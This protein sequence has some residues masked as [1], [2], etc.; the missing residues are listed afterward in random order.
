[1]SHVLFYSTYNCNDAFID[2]KFSNYTTNFFKVKN[3]L[4]REF[5]KNITVKEYIDHIYFY[6]SQ[7]MFIFAPSNTGKSFLAQLLCQY[8]YKLT[9]SK[10]RKASV[11]FCYHS[12]PPTPIPNTEFRCHKGLPLLGDILN[13]K[14][15]SKTDEI[16]LGNL[17]ICF[18][19]KFNDFC[20]FVSKSLMI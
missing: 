12:V 4:S 14:E 16:I 20:L 1:M 13:Y 9:D 18:L 6:L 8:H 19:D 10:S 2:I 15:E 17:L 5:L 11:I 3:T 7:Q